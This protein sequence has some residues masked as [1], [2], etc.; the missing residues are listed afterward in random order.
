MKDKK[1]NSQEIKVWGYFWGREPI[2]NYK[3]A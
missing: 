1:Q 3:P 2:K